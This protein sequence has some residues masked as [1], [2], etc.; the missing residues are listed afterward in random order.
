MFYFFLSAERTAI[1]NISILFPR[2][3]M[4]NMLGFALLIQKPM[5]MILGIDHTHTTLNNVSKMPM[6]YA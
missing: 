2:E 5:F 3:L 1:N 4:V 6:A